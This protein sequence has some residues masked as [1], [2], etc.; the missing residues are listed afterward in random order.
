MSSEPWSSTP[1]ISHTSSPAQ[2]WDSNNGYN[3]AAIGAFSNPAHR[4]R[5]IACVNAMAGI[6]NPATFRAATETLMVAVEHS[7]NWLQSLGYS[8]TEGSY[9]WNLQNDAEYLRTLVEGV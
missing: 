6:E 1:N 3:Y 9:V 7:V 4:D 8:N 2:I 5:A